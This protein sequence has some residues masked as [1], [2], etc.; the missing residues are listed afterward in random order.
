[1]KPVSERRLALYISLF[2]VVITIL[3]NQTYRPYI[4]QNKICDFHLADTL[5]SWV[6]VPA[7]SLFFWGISHDRFF[8]G[9][10]G[11][12][13][14]SIVYEFIGLT[15]DWLDIIALFLS[16]GLTYGIYLIVKN[17]RT[18]SGISKRIHQ[19]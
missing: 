5:T 13:A 10:I 15:F 12:W 11:S 16:S 4:Y 17:R 14:G 8:K 1:M 2:L 18:K 19:A 7:G 6:S 9:F 3:L